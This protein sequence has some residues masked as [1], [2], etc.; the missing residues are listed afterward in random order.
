MKMTYTN[1]FK[2]F[3]VIIFV[4]SSC[5]NDASDNYVALV[6]DIPIIEYEF[7][8][9]Y[10]F[11]PHLA[12]YHDKI[13]AKKVILST[14]IAEKL[15]ALESSSTSQLPNDVKNKL[16]Q[17]K[18][19]III[20]QFR[21]DSVE[22]QINVTDSELQKEYLKALKEVDIKYIVFKSYN[23]AK[24]IKQKIENGMSF[25]KAVRD[26][27]NLQG[28]GKES[29]PEKTVEW[30]TETYDIEE[31]IFALQ[32]DEISNPIKINGDYYLIKLQETRSNQYPNNMDYTN[33][34]S[35]LKDR[36]LR[37]KIKDKYIVFFENNIR[38]R[39]GDVD[40]KKLNGAFELIIKNISF[41]KNTAQS[42]PF[43]DD[44]ALSDEI[45]LSYESQQSQLRDM[46][47]VRFSDHSS[48]ALEELM[49]VLKYG[50]FSF[51]YKNKISFKKSFKQNILLALEYE[52]IYQLAKEADYENN[53]HVLKD[54]KLWEAYYRANDYRFQLL[55]QAESNIFINDSTKYR[56]KTNLSSLQQ[57]RLD[58]FDDYLSVL[59]E[60]YSIKINREK[61]NSLKLSK[62]DMVVM[63]THF[64]HRLVVP[65]TEPLTGLPQW[66]N[67][68][69]TIFKKSGIT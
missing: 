4:L 41:S 56:S 27:M 17:H 33:R 36:I 22:N 52:A 64:A 15:L 53:G 48:W 60:K 67:I 26:Y 54:T 12:Q 43:S 45:Y 39:L 49:V 40:W 16:E 23:E 2:L 69:Q 68:M 61:F 6:D 51:N 38:S 59:S 21:R 62:T 44:K 46:I 28:W 19:E 18:K 58:Y 20:E 9:R 65:L 11:N 8:L 24:R 50:P 13:E 7:T 5:E 32:S 10:N 63:K 57:F 25:E 35:A 31:R 34:L 66:R 55:K 47:V 1:I 30:N 37:E 29:I 14:L 3:I 42:Q